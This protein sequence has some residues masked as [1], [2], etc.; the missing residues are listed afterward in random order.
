[1]IILHGLGAKSQILCSV[2]QTGRKLPLLSCVRFV[3]IVLGKSCVLSYML[4][5]F[6]NKY[7]KYGILKSKAKP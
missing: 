4:S 1:M 3:S 7:V 2:A 5:I 6:H